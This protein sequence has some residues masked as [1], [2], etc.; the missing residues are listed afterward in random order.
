MTFKMNVFGGDLSIVN[1]SD[2]LT[3]G[4]VTYAREFLFEGLD[5][6][7]E[8]TIDN[9]HQIITSST[10]ENRFPNLTGYNWMRYVKGNNILDIEG[11]IESISF[12]HQFARK[13]S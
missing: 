12:T 8:I 11:N 4:S 7:E 9:D 5:A 13:I 6:E 3:S 2:V 1:N 10:G